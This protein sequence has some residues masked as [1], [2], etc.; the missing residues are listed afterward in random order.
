[1]KL[2]KL[3]FLIF[4]EGLWVWESSGI[5]LN[6]T[7]WES[8]QPN[9]WSFSED[10]EDCMFIYRISKKWGASMCISGGTGKPLCQIDA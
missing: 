8:G 2:D 5:P 6:Y 7:N 1:M 9:K 4:Q 10:Y 3:H